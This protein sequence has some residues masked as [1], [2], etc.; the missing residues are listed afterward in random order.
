MVLKKILSALLLFGF[1]EASENLHNNLSNKPNKSSAPKNSL[2]NCVT[3]IRDI[4]KIILAYLFT[5][6]NPIKLLHHSKHC[7]NRTISSIAFTP[8]D[9]YLISC[10]LSN[11]DTYKNPK[12]AIHNSVIT[13][14]N[15][16]SGKPEKTI[17]CTRSR[18]L[19][20]SPNNKYLLCTDSAYDK[21][22]SLFNSTTFDPA[23]EIVQISWPSSAGITFSPDGKYLAIGQIGDLPITLY[24]ISAKIRDKGKMIGERPSQYVYT[25]FSAI[26]YS[27][28]GK[29]IAA[30][31]NYSSYRVKVWDVTSGNEILDI[32]N[33]IFEIYVTQICFTHDSKNLVF[34]NNYG[35]LTILDID[36]SHTR[37][38]YQET[39]GNH[40]SKIVSF[41]ISRDGKFLFLITY[42]AGKIMYAVHL[43]DLLT[44]KEI[45]SFVLSTG[46]ATL[47]SNGFYIAQVTANKD[48]EILSNQALEI[49]NV[50]SEEIQDKK[51]DSAKQEA[52]RNEES[53]SGCVIM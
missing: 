9:K 6:D 39:H 31:T 30:T 18:D 37:N 47:S 22:G 38:I 20:V 53:S 4:Q 25:S 19:T 27:P 35:M 11:C 36:N 17:T 16:N 43:F 13:Q 23:G 48:I 12:S 40:A 24:D 34:S 1:L 5:W 45:D 3:G 49:E 7:E 10:G 52:G 33:G 14:W 51:G 26:A 50:D 29:M 2:L 46:V 28:D 42:D 44:Y 21:V 32:G 8:N 41:T 15:L